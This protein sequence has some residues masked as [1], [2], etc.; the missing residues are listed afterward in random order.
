MNHLNYAFDSKN[1]IWRYIVVLILSFAIA[2]TIGAI[3]IG[4]I[5]VL[6]LI[7][8]GGLQSTPEN[9]M[10][11]STYGIDQNLGLAALL[12]SFFVAFVG[13]VLLLKPFHNRTLQGTINGTNKIRWKKISIGFLVWAVL[14]LTSLI[15]TLITSPG[16]LKLQFEWS[17]FIPLFFIA[18]IL[19]PF[20]TAYEEVTFRGYL[21]QG[22]ATGTKSKIW[23]LVIT[24]LVFGLLHSINPEVKEYGFMATMPS[25]IGFGLIFGL[26]T[27]L[28]DGVEL[29]IGI[30]TANNFLSA[31]LVSSPH[32]ALV[33]PAIYSVDKI[34]PYADMLSLY[35]FGI[36]AIIIFSFIYKWN[37]KT[38]GK[39]VEIDSEKTN[40]TPE[41]SL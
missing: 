6:G 12:F 25:Y 27:L 17:S 15:I 38:L 31:I 4:I 5:M 40:G 14:M 16:E 41:N 22:I 1:Q 9:M 35:I 21:L 33:T 24:S 3:P 28:D 29:A 26:I 8:S 7:K 34:D 2:N 13:F 32:S 36:I 11:F 23:A 10:D 19:I 20:Q 30:H 39:R 18:L 37:W